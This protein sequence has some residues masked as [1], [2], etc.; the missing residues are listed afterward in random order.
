MS[1]A[2]TR[3]YKALAKPY[4]AFALAFKAGDASF[5]QEIE[6]TRETF[7]QDGNAGLAT[8]CVHA[9]RRMQIVALRD[10]YVTL[11]VG[12]IAQKGFDVARPVGETEGP[13][14]VERVIL[15]MVRNGI[16]R[17]A[18]RWRALITTPFCRS[19]EPK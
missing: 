18:V 13:D 15:G 12:E 16:C 6:L 4:E 10:T 2:T 5:R 14:E 17:W 8:Q 3:T 11:G 19:S 1:A 7:N 9:F